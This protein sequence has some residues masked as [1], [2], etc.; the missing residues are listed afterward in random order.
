MSKETESSPVA[1]IAIVEE[2]IVGKY[3]KYGLTKVLTSDSPSPEAVYSP[4][5]LKIEP[6]IGVPF[7]CKIQFGKGR[8]R[9]VELAASAKPVETK[10]TGFVESDSEIGSRRSWRIKLVPGQPGSAYATLD[11]KT[12]RA[13]RFAHVDQGQELTFLALPTAADWTVTE[14]LAPTLF[15]AIPD[16]LTAYHAFSLRNWDA[17]GTFKSASFAVR[18]PGLSMWPL[19]NVFSSLLRAQSIPSLVGLD[20]IDP[21]ALSRAQDYISHAQTVLRAGS[22]EEIDSLRI[23]CLEVALVWDARGYWNVKRLIA[24]VSM[25][26]P[27]PHEAIDWVHGTLVSV[28]DFAGKESFG[29]G[30]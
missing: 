4:T 9:V 24:P 3:G 19:V 15:S 22:P 25:R 6:E 5:V 20:P 28:G 27:N 17:D 8:W 10:L 11:L 29:A 13:A 21:D 14:I 16:A 2:W 23:G 18:V 30:H 12:L 1:V 7:D 26:E